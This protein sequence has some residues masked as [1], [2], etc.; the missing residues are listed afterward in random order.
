MQEKWIKWEPIKG[1]Q[2]KYYIDSIVDNLDGFEMI[3]SDCNDRNKRVMVT[4]ENSVEA[5]RSTDETCRTNTICDLRDMYGLDFYCEWTF[6]KVE[7]SRYLRWVI[8][9]SCGIREAHYLTH[10]SFIAGESIVDIIA[11]YEPK[12]QFKI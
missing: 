9:E 11:P 12:V 8:E 7:N 6:F 5:Y 10:F 2:L 1:L 4:F 3:L